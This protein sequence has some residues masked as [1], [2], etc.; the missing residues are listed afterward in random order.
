MRATSVQ[1][2]ASPAA[3]ELSKE[4][5]EEDII[6]QEAELDALEARFD[7]DLARIEF[8]LARIERGLARYA[9]IKTIS[10]DPQLAASAAAAAA[11]A[12]SATHLAVA[13]QTCV[14]S[15]GAYAGTRSRQTT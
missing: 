6:G 14:G 9:R 13:Y 5:L 1:G 8:L 10:G 2:S 12:A 15:G 7:R 3:A 4:S 11:A